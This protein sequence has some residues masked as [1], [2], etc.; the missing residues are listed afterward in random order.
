MTAKDTFFKINTTLNAGGKLLDLTSPIVMGVLNI[1]P[2]SFFE[3]SRT[4]TEKAIILQAEKMLSEGADILDLGAYSSRPDADD[5]SEEEEEGRLLLALNAIVRKFPDAIISVDTFRASIAEKAIENGA[6]II[7]DISGGNLDNKMFETV[8]KLKVPYILMHMKGTPQTMKNLNQYDDMLQEICY[9]FSEKI[10]A[11]K[12]A[13]VKDIILD[14]GFGFAKNI[15]QNF[16]LLN[17][18]SDFKIFELPILAGLSR[19]SMVWKTLKIKPEEALNGSSILNTIAIL[20]GANI[21]RVHDVKEA[22]EVI[23]LL[24]HLKQ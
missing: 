20:N 17:K 7:N 22:R 10:A 5:I 19:K 4:Q 13:G 14:P 15:E 2:D 11:L 12:K 3:G 9:Y 21:L 6:H 18:L 24:N 1:T 8:G 16:E 23:S